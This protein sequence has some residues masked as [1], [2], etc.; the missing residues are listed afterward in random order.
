[1][2]F[3]AKVFANAGNQ[4]LGIQVYLSEVLIVFNQNDDGISSLVLLLNYCWMNRLTHCGFCR[5][6]PGLLPQY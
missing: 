2:A 1:M 5:K 6:I 3:A 4:T